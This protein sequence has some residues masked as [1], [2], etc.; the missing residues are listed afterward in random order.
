MRELDIRLPDGWT[1]DRVEAERKKHGIGEDMVPIA[2]AKGM[3]VAWGTITSVRLIQLQ[4]KVDLLRSALT[5]AKGYVEANLIDADGDELETSRAAAV[6][7]D[8]KIIQGAID[9]ENYGTENRPSR[10]AASRDAGSQR[11][12]KI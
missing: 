10:N 4:S 11:I 2:H 9:G 3:V 1:W 8:L 6:K 7:A 12:R 5:I